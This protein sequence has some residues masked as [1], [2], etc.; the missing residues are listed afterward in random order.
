MRS[1]Y[2]DLDD[3]TQDF[4]ER[5]RDEPEI[6][7]DFV[8]KYELSWVYHEHALE[9]V[10]YT[11]QELVAALEP[12][13]VTDASIVQAFQEVRNL[14]AAID[15]VR[16]EAA[17]KRPRIHLTLVRRLHE[18]L[19]AGL[20]GRGASE[21]RKDMPL[22][23]SYYHEIAQPPKIAGLLQKVVEAT[24]TA[25]FRQSHPVQRAARLQHAFMQVYPY[26][27]GS[28]KIARL[29]ANLI[30]L[31][32]GFLPCIIHSVDRQRYYDAFRLPEAALRDLM[33]EAIDNGMA[34]A[35]K[36]F[37]GALAARA[38]RASR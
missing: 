3:R 31:H 13:P 9:G 5:M 10:I 37:A 33:L 34:N 32:E 36:A 20:P 19:H 23:R 11:V 29:L 30:L 1:R 35:E 27:E 17:A 4:A 22:H 8:R 7:Q 12:Q 28:G 16:V 15:L 38:K 21:Y 18:T 25:D 6:A 26:T 2:L 14:K 24:D